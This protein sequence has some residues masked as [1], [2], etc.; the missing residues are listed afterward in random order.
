MLF[1]N[2]V[3]VGLNS[4]L[5]G[6][7]ILLDKANRHGLI[8]GAT[9]SGKT[10]TLK[11]LAEAF[12]DAG[13][14]VFLA[15]VKGDISG[16]CKAGTDSEK[17]RERV[18]KLGINN[19]EF[20]AYP[21]MFWDIFGEKGLPLRTTIT[22]FGPVLLAR[23][24][25]LNQIQSD[26]LN[27]VFKIADEEGLLLID[28][29][30]L[31]SMLNYVSENAEVYR[32]S[33]G[34]IAP[35]SIGAIMRGIVSLESRGGNTYFGEPA[36]DLADWFSQ[37]T[38]G[39]GMINVL[40]SS[41]LIN[42][43]LAY[44]SFMLW[45]LAELFENLP[46]VGDT[47]KPKMVFFFDEAHLLFKDTPKVLLN[48]I[49]QVIK[50]IRSKG[51]GVFFITQNP[52]DIPDSVLAQLGNKVQHALRAYTPAEQK[53]VKA[54]ANSYRVNPKFKTDEVINELGT[55]EAV[56]S[57][58]TND[59]SP[60]VAEKVTVLPPQSLMGAVDEITRQATILASPLNKKYKD[61][62]DRDSA[63]EFLA[64]K[65]I[66]EDELRQKQKNDRLLEIEAQKQEKL[67]QKENEKLEKQRQKQE[68]AD[69]RRV[70]RSVATVAGS[71]VGTVGREV[72]NTLGKSIGG[73]FGKRLGGNLGASLGRGILKNLFKL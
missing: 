43:S 17:I 1:E 54:A 71:V 30:D 55:G 26:I 25:N 52:T 4:D 6:Q 38:S 48:K 72:G 64:R 23:L 69:Q 53:A 32:E 47:P 20:K 11:V 3:L 14:P 16:I 60:S 36:L 12:S 37:D 5:E 49:E 42:D 15:D 50:L 68:A 58:I 27:I 34:N 67:L 8:A 9:G 66:E 31:K 61:M 46:E 59:G 24:L 22:E 56:V 33:Y 28:V 18:S 57:F 45:L 29:K 51:I 63:Y 39:K 21:T 40:D 62:I 65:K 19:F 70:K 7:Y 73:S 13:V 44:S 2:K 35:Q 41:S 10:I